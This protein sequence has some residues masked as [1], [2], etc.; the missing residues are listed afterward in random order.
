LQDLCITVNATGEV[1]A[2]ATLAHAPS[3]TLHVNK[4]L[5]ALNLSGK[6]IGNDGAVAIAAALKINKTLHSLMLGDTGIEADGAVAIAEALKVNQTLRKL[7]LSGN[8]IGVDGVTVITV[9]WRSNHGMLHELDVS[10]KIGNI[11][12][13]AIAMAMVTNMSLQMIEFGR[14]VPDCATTALAIAAIATIEDA[15]ARNRN[16]LQ[17]LRQCYTA[18]QLFVPPFDRLIDRAG[19]ASGSMRIPLSM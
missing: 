8:V 11:G 14:L 18:V 15:L 9:T 12:I 1:G 10:Y 2:A 13:W 3:G 5:Q 7:D 6:M 4:T 19:L 16:N 17:E